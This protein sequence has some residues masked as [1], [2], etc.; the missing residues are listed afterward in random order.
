MQKWIISI[1]LI[2]VCFLTACSQRSSPTPVASTSTITQA[3]VSHQTVTN[4]SSSALNNVIYFKVVHA[5]GTPI[6]DAEINYANLDAPHP[7]EY[8]QMLRFTDENGCTVWLHAETGKHEI[9]VCF[10]DVSAGPMTT[11]VFTEEDFGTEITIVVAE[12]YSNISV[13]S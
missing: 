5:D 11:Y 7:E 3:T 8:G 10:S 13:I 12:D 2:C 9:G 1:L 6:A 4:S